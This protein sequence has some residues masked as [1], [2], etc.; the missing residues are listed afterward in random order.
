MLNLSGGPFEDYSN[1]IQKR[2]LKSITKVEPI[3]FS[4]ENA[5]KYIVD[6]CEMKR[7]N[8]LE[9][10]IICSKERLCMSKSFFAFLVP[11]SEHN[12]YFNMNSIERVDVSVQYECEKRNFGVQT[13]ESDNSFEMSD[14]Q[15]DSVCLH[16]R[17]C[18]IAIADNNYFH[19]GLQL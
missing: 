5:L 15:N 11:H 4:A 18:I 10:Q 3:I 14:C 7:F 8:L 9:R 13:P 16:P 1:N 2:L 17:F 6:V 19:D 12:E